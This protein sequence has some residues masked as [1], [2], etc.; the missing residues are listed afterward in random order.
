MLYKHSYTVLFRGWWQDKH[1][2]MFSTDAIFFCNRIS[3]PTNGQIC[4]CRTYRCQGPSFWKSGTVGMGCCS[5]SLSWIACTS[6]HVD[7]NISNYI[8]WWS[9]F[10]LRNALRCIL[11]PR[12][13]N[14]LA[15]P[16]LHF[17]VGHGWIMMNLNLC[18]CMYVHTMQD[19]HNKKHLQEKQ[20]RL[21]EWNEA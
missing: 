21:L 13:W 18:T 19:I 3:L 12:P 17:I 15:S 7:P 10:Q 16:V 9:K 20:G 5:R 4:W 8:L 1:L 14:Q 6:T 2:Y 11:V